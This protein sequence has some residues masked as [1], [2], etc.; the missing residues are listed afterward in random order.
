MPPCPAVVLARPDL[1]FPGSL[2]EFQ[3]LF[4]DD[5]DGP[6]TLKPFAGGTGSSADGAANLANPAA[7]STGR[8]SPVRNCQ[9]DN[10]LTAGTV[11]ERTRTGAVD[12]ILGRIPHFE[13]YVRHVGRPIPASA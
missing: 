7:S 6:L 13:P 12:L 4:R 2:P 9:R 8:T 11:M 3:R 10:A 5:A 1:P